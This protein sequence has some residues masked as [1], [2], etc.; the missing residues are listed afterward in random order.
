MFLIT[1]L[2][3]RTGQCD[4]SDR[5]SPGK[6]RPVSVLF[7]ITTLQVRTGQCVVSDHH[8]PGTDRPVCCF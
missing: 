3:V 7:L 5:H 4:V 6:D 8:S 2:Q 1:T